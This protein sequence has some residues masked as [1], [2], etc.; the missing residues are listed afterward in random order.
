MT[1]TRDKVP[2]QVFY[3]ANYVPG[4]DY[5]QVVVLFLNFN[6][7]SDWHGRIKLGTNN[8]STYV[9]TWL[10]N[11]QIN[12]SDNVDAAPVELYADPSTRI[13]GSGVPTV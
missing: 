6:N 9:S 13:L 4:L 8:F 11:A 7:H 5:K 1:V 2:V 10:G 12:K 3:V